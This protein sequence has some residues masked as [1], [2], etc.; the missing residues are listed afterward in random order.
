MG[1]GDLTWLTELGR[2]SPLV[3]AIGVLILVW[4]RDAKR[5]DRLQESL[6]TALRAVDQLTANVTTLIH[7]T[8]RVADAVDGWGTTAGRHRRPGSDE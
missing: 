1:I 3:L 6:Y 7:T 5:A 2:G 8:Q 4:R